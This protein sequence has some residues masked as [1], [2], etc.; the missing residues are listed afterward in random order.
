MRY[1]IEWFTGK[2]WETVGLVH[3]PDWRTQQH[4][5]Y[6]VAAGPN[7]TCHP[8]VLKR[9]RSVPCPARVQAPARFGVT[10]RRE[11]RAA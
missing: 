4:P 9:L 8:A 11:V 5:T 2:R 7:G 6:P 3:N 1:R 10:L